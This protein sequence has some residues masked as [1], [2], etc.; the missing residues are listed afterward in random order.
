[1]AAAS[2]TIC[3]RAFNYPLAFNQGM[4]KPAVPNNYAPIEGG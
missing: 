1:M 2:I 4:D 3:L